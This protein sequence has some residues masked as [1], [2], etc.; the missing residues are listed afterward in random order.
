MVAHKVG[1]GAILL[2]EIIPPRT[3]RDGQTQQ[4]IRVQDTMDGQSVC[5]AAC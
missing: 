3:Q 2:L 4:T 5:S 1:M